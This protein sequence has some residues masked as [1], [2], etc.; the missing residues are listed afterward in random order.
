MRSYLEFSDHYTE[1]N[2]PSQLSDG[3]R[4]V[5]EGVGNWLNH[6][7]KAIAHALMGAADPFIWQM[8]DRNGNTWWIIDDSLTGS[9]FHALSE[10]EV[11][12]WIEQHY[13]IQ[14]HSLSGSA[15]NVNPRITG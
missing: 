5:F 2:E 15:R 4:P 11:C 3:F 7:V 6:T 10:E 13:Y 1:P 8:T 14:S 12:A 9:R